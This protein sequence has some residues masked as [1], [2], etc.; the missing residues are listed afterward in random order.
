MVST[1]VGIISVVVATIT[2]IWSV[3]K[4]SKKD[5]EGRIELQSKLEGRLQTVT[6]ISLDTQKEVKLLREETKE[7]QISTAA[8][9]RDIKTL[10]HNDARL[11]K[12]LDTFVNMVD[13]INRLADAVAKEKGA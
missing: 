2:L 5:S 11:E 3:W 13:A 6:D 7:Q 12:Q 1:W 8:M 10:Y 9:A 4:S